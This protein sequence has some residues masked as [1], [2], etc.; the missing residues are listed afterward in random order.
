MTVPPDSALYADSHRGRRPSPGPAAAGR[1][2]STARRSTPGAAT[3]RR[4][5]PPDGRSSTARSRRRQPVAD[6]VTKEQFG[7]FELEI[8]WKIGEAGNAGIFYRGTEEY[9]H[10][11]WSAPEYQ[12]LDD[13]K[14]ADNK[15]RLTC[16][17]AAYGALS[18]ARRAP[19]AGRRMEHDAHR[20]QGRAR[21]ALAERR[22]ARRV[23]AVEP[24]L[25]GQ[26][27][28]Q[29]VRQVAEVRPGETRPHRH[30]GRPRGRAGVP[31][32]PH[33]RDEVAMAPPTPIPPQ[34]RRQGRPRHR[35]VH[36]RAAPRAGPGLPGAE[37]PPQHRGGGGR[38]ARPPGAHQ[39]GEPERGGAVRRR[40][41]LRR[42]GLR[43]A[44]K[45]I[46]ALRS[47]STR[48]SSRSARRR[49]RATTA[50]RHGVDA[51][52]DGPGTVPDHR[53]GGAAEDLAAAAAR[54]TR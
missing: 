45:E 37:R 28:G 12:L 18:V 13:I 15:T 23:R 47:A 11:Y 17:G 42:P 30:P 7:D 19:E 20:R 32:D 22:Q 21:R 10:I 54:A 26:G 39:H 5:C 38:R 34:V 2:S 4:R 43:G 48:T 46:A 1:C 9:E 8:E 24:R 40:L 29:Q 50:R 44:R 3:R 25:G 33:S 53:H 36:H 41:G 6:I 27:Q 16:A 49:R 51:A 35:R 31:H 14:A 52:D